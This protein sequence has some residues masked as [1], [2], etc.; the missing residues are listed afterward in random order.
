MK[1]AGVAG[2]KRRAAGWTLLALGVL[3]AGVWVASGWWQ[4][5]GGY[6]SVG[7]V[8]SGGQ[9]MIWSTDMKPEGPLISMPYRMD[10]PM[11]YWNGWY[12]LRERHAFQRSRGPMYIVNSSIAGSTSTNV[13][14]VLWP[15]PLLLWTTA[16]LLL[17]SGILARRRANTGACPKCGYSLAG[18]GDGGPC[19]ECGKGAGTK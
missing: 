7:F 18:L 13:G 12:D 3:V 2:R 9:I 14:I 16:A 10:V 8:V 15:I 6:K 1:R 11:T 17:P 4:E 19:P 5:R